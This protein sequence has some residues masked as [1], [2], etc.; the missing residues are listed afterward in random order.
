[1]GAG[2]GG[3]IPSSLS[4]RGDLNPRHSV[5][6]TEALN[7]ELLMQAHPS[8]LFSNHPAS[9]IRIRN[10]EKYR[11]EATCPMMMYGCSTGMPPIHVRM[12]TSAISVQNR[13]WV[14]GRKVR[15]RCLDV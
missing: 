5:Y 11:T 4:S 10:S 12:P 15:L 7:A 8:A 3:S 1:M 2:G 13:N 6:K 14:A 9:G